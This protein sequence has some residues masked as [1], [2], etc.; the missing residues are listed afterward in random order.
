MLT[1]K[2]RTGA[3]YVLSGGM[4]ITSPKS[5]LLEVVYRSTSHFLIT[6]RR[7]PVSCLLAYLR[8]HWN[9]QDITSPA[10][11]HGMYISIV[12]YGVWFKTFCTVSQQPPLRLMPSMYIL[13]GTSCRRKTLK[14]CKPTLD[15]GA[16]RAALRDR[17][18]QWSWVSAISRVVNDDPNAY[19]RSCRNHIAM[20][21]KLRLNG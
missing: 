10:T 2:R 4:L 18:S 16:Y 5:G 7:V 12:D 13:T 15:R 14:R 19:A 8:R 1:S 17:A 9:G 6:K 21:D 11:R 20:L 3:Y